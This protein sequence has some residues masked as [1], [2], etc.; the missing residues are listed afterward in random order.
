MFPPNLGDWRASEN[1]DRE[2]FEGEEMTK[3]NIAALGLATLGTAA[4]SLGLMAGAANAAIIGQPGETMGLALGAPLPEGVFLNELESYGKRDGQNNHLGVNV[5]IVAWSTPWTFLDSRLEVLY[6]APFTHIDGS[7]PGALN[8][9]DAYSQGLLFALAHDFG[10]GFNAVII[11]GP[12]TPDNFT[13]A[14]R[15]AAADLRFAVSYVAGGYNATISVNYAGNFGGKLTGVVG[16]VPTGFD[17]NI[18][19]DYTLTKHFDKLEVGVVGTAYT[20]IGGPIPTHPGGV[21]IGGLLG[22]DFGRFTVDAMV[23]REVAVRAGGYGL[24]PGAIPGG[25]ETRGWLRLIVPLYVAPKPVAPV[26]A[27]Y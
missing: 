12:R 26:V 8:R 21:A 22:Y 15:G 4:L 9:V 18:F 25:K 10:N 19:L 24:G 5:P 20:D 14:G 16:G 6:A 17:D 13:Q 11:A 1:R 27:R 3:T 2:V 23:T 7:G